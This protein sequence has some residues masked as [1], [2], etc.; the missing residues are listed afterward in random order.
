M[1]LAINTITRRDRSLHFEMDLI[2]ATYEG[3]FNDSGTEIRGEWSQQGN[4]WPL[5]FSRTETPAK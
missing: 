1:G 2:G 4:S 3:K 5:I